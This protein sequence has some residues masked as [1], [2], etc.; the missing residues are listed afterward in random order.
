MLTDLADQMPELGGLHKVV[1][2]KKDHSDVEVGYFKHLFAIVLRQRAIKLLSRGEL[3]LL[4]LL[5]QLL[6]LG[7]LSP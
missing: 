6:C 4:L 1:I 2:F 7:R 3:F 5:L